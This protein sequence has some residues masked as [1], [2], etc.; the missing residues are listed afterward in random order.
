MEN[1]KPLRDSQI[2]ILGVCIVIA[3]VIA[4]WI[5]AQGA[6]R[7]VQFNQQQITVTGSAQKEIK[8]DYI[9]WRGSVQMREADL[10]VAYQNLRAD[11]EKV[12]AYLLSKG[13]APEEMLLTQVSTE[14]IYKK[15]EKGTDTNEIEAYR[16]WQSVEVRSKNTDA[17]SVI[18]RESTELIDQGIKFESNSPQYFYSELDSLKVSMLAEAT[19][20]AKL[21]A[22]KM[23]S[24]TGNKIGLMRQA[25]MGVFQ[26]TPANST[27]VSDWG[28][29]DTSSLYKKVTAVVNVSFAIQ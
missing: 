15:S 26:I 24:A 1:Y 27:E 11:L 3:T 16:L 22:T 21:R 29:N 7:V 14:S 19:E 4:S 12:K 23:T 8:S 5:L 13:V 20:N 9:V 18:S 10:K 17:V 28:V 6:F 25:R 2:V